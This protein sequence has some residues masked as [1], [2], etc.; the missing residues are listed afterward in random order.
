MGSPTPTSLQGHW[1]AAPRRA[2]V[3]A[4]GIIIAVLLF[5][6]LLAVHADYGWE[7]FDGV[8]EY[9][10]MLDHPPMDMGRA[11]VDKIYQRDP[12]AA[13]ELKH[14]WHG[15]MSHNEEKVWLGV[16]STSR[17]QWLAVRAKGAEETR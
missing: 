8:T 10:W 1:R 7:D 11:D 12:K 14:I 5:A 2:K 6:V 13:E 9:Q 15:R 17:E 16:V 3:H 4:V